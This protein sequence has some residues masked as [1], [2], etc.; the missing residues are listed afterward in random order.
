MKRYSPVLLLLFVSIPCLATAAVRC[1]NADLSKLSKVVYVSPEV[2]DDTANCGQTAASPCKTINKAIEKCSG[3]GCAVLARYG[4]YDPEV[5]NIADGVSLY[6][7]C[8][9]DE[10]PYRYRSTIIG[11]PAIQ[12][13]GINKPT[14]VEGFVILGSNAMKSGEASI[15]LTVSNSTGLVLRENLMASGKGGNGGN[16]RT[17]EPGQGQSGSNAS[18]TAG[19]AGGIAC[20]LNPPAGSTGRGG[21]GA[22][23]RP[24]SSSCNKLRGVCDCSDRP[25]APAPVGANGVNSGSISGGA[26]GHAGSAGCACEG[27]RARS[28]GTGWDGGSGRMGAFSTQGG[29][30]NPD[31]KGSFTG[32]TWQ[33]N[34]GGT[35]LAGQVG[36][37]G[38]GAGP[39]G[40][41]ALTG[42]GTNRNGYAGGGGGGG[43]CGGPGGTGAEQGGASVP[44]VLF[45]SSVTGLGASNTFIPGPGGQGGKGGVGAQGG[46]GGSGGRGFHG[47]QWDVTQTTILGADV[48][49]GRIPGFGGNGGNG[50]QGGAGG[51]GAGGNGGPSFGIALVNSSPLPAG[52]VIIYRAQ[53][54]SGGA[55]GTGGQNDAANKGQN[56]EAGSRGFS[57]D[58]NSIVSFTSKNLLVGA[59]Q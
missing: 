15:A 18:S 40:F 56:G 35:G 24:I 7:S 23:L 3:G 29:S 58:R 46:R 20:V 16:G 17:P 6:G 19:G 39:G 25:E 55:L 52:G 14:V 44:L 42:S 59:N 22:D 4:V 1:A 37:G 27:G 47:Q 26:G 8:I 43:G 38:G 33:P 10:T 28:A 50:G 12:A 2:K 57:D 9:F 51:G 30:P 34:A 53:P 21:K 49:K 32:T 36:S 41:S 54:G 5:I 31:T 11:N 48:C 13:K 45:A